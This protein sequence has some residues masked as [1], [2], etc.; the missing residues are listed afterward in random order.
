MGLNRALN[1]SAS[2]IRAE[3][4]QMEV[5]ASNIANINTTRTMDGGPYRRRMAVFEETPVTFQSALDKA[6]AKLDGGGVGFREIIEDNAPLQKVY[7]PTHP[8][9]DQNG[10]VSMPN[11]SISKEMVDMIYNS[12]LYEAN[13]T[14]YNATKQ[15][16]RETL[17][18]Q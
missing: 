7:N 13:I 6:S 15:M 17:Q 1:I 8:D 12:K 5:I 11:V 9:A 2:G 3:S 14:V 16:V 4:L 10:F 18:L